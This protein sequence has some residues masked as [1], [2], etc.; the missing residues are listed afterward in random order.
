MLLCD[1]RSLLFD[2]ISAQCA[3]KDVERE[4]YWNNLPSN[5]ELKTFS[6]AKVGKSRGIRK[7][8]AAEKKRHDA[9]MKRIEEKKQKIRKPRGM[10]KNE[11]GK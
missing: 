1:M 4:R 8:N 9:M 7:A 6:K 11:T 3:L 10:F 5:R 2:L